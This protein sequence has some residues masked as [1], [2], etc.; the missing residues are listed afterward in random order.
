MGMKRVRIFKAILW[1]LILFSLAINV[2]FAK[3]NIIINGS[4]EEG[5]NNPDGWNK[6]DH[7]AFWSN[8][9]HTGI[10]SLLLNVSSSNAEWRMNRVNITAGASYLF[11]F[12]VKGHVKS[13]K[14]YVNIRF[15][16][17]YEGI[18]LSNEK[19][20]QI[21]GNYTEWKQINATLTVP[22]DAKTFDVYFHAENATGE[23]YTDDY[24]MI[25]ME[26][27]SVIAQWFNELFYGSGKWLTLIIMM[28]IIIAVCSKF[29]LGGTLF[30]PITIFLGFDY[31]RNVP[32][33]NDFIWGALMMICTSIFI[34]VMA[35]RKA[36]RD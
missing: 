22:S 16:S 17:D 27:T 21:N 23:V 25:Q 29:P 19:I 3:E 15:W 35:I 33:S 26:E 7:G 30:L 10:H 28:A 36:M 4:V 2:C 14:F 1:I 20:F 31:L 24:L 6:S 13:G 11:S 18:N 8:I 5:I 32:S 34:L 9:G 12:W